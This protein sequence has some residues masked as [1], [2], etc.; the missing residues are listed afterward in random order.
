M[1]HIYINKNSSDTLIML[2]GTGGNEEQMLSLANLID[3]D[4]NILSIRGN[5]VENGMNRFFKRD[6]IGLY[7]IENYKFET[8][9]LI[10]AINNFSKEYKFKLEYATIVGFSNGANIALGIIQTNP[11]INNYILYSPDYINKDEG[12]NNLEGKNIYIS[13]AENDPYV[14]FENMETLIN[15]LNDKHANVKVLKT[16]GHQINNKVLEN[17]IEWYKKIKL[18]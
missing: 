16:S 14:N 17:S 9:N 12:F 5:V 4:A 11:I 8:N 6:G 2:H 18:S 7:N 13:T 3:K 1:K 10:D 15:R